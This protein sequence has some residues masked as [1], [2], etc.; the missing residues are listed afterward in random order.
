MYG[1]L[2]LAISFL[3]LSVSGASSLSPRGLEHPQTNVSL[4]YP[5]GPVQVGVG[6][7]ISLGVVDLQSGLGF[8]TDMII[9]LD[10]EDGSPDDHQEAPFTQACSAMGYHGPFTVGFHVNKTGR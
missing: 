7:D 2:L 6:Q 5:E 4:V 9:T 3:N 10:H 1:P 8:R